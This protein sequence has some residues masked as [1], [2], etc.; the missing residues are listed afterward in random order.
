M[1]RSATALRQ[2]GYFRVRRRKVALESFR[3][4]STGSPRRSDRWTWGPEEGRSYRRYT[5]K[6]LPMGRAYWIDL[7]SHYN[8][9]TGIT[10]ELRHFLT[11]PAAFRK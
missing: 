8:R 2:R 7:Y 4:S 1:K 10:D 5:K 3:K 11:F 6:Q 9:C